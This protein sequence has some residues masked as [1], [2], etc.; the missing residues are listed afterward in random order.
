MYLVVLEKYWQTFHT[1]KKMIGIKPLNKLSVHLDHLIKGRL[2]L[3]VIIGLIIGSGLGMVI[4]PS[5]G[6]VSEQ[7]SLSLT[8]WLDLPGIIFMRLVQ[9]I[10]IPLIFAS[11]IAGIVGNASEA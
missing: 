11:I 8:N 10:M 1:P 9:M 3:K 7:L 6:L 5:S 2:W 4:N